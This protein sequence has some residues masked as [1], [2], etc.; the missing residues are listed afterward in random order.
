MVISEA[1][2]HLPYSCNALQRTYLAHNDG[3][4]AVPAITLQHSQRFSTTFMRRAL[5]C[6]EVN[7]RSSCSL[8]S[9]THCQ[10]ASIKYQRHVAFGS[11]MHCDVEGRVAYEFGILYDNLLLCCL[12]HLSQHDEYVC[13]YGM[14]SMYRGIAA[15]S[16]APK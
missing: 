15:C 7:G 16:H 4:A 6:N 10:Q 12:S 14:M 5:F 3:I 9:D 1:F 8:P 2:F 11:F 13:R